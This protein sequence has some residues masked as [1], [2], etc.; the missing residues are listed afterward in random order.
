MKL[1]IA[2]IGLA[3]LCGVALGAGSAVAMPNGL[4]HADQIAGQAAMSSRSAGSAMPGAAASGGAQLFTGP[5]LGEDRVPSGDRARPS[6]APMPGAAPGVGVEAP[7]LVRRLC[8]GR[9][10]SLLELAPRL[11]VNG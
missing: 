5:M 6:T 3:A 4:P 11:V 2:V 8:L 10:A 1:K 7:G 9:T